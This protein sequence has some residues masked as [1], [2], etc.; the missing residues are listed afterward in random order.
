[1]NKRFK[2]YMSVHGSKEELS[3][4]TKELRKIGYAPYTE[5]NFDGKIWGEPWSEITNFIILNGEGQNLWAYH[6]HCGL[7]DIEFRFRLPYQ[8]EQAL[9]AATETIAEDETL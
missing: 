3:A 8:K 5:V 1:M 4:F 6:N 9:L 7:C 2:N